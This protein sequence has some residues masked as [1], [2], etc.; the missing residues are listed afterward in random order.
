MHFLV[1]P[2]MSKSFR[3]IVFYS[4]GI[5]DDLN[6][7]SNAT[8]DKFEVLGS[9]RFYLSED[10]CIL[11]KVTSDKYSRVKNPVKW[12]LHDYLE[13]R[14]LLQA[15]AAKEY[16]SL[17][18]LRRTGLRTP[19]CYGWGV[20]LQ[21][22]NSGGSLL[23]MEHVQDARPGGDVFDTMTEAERLAFLIRFSQ[24]VALLA[25]AGYVHRDL[26]YNNLLLDEN[27]SIIW[28]DA[29]VRRLPRRKSR[30]WPAIH[31]SLTVSKLRGEDYRAFVEQQLQKRLAV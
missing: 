21:S 24:E 15:D 13:K 3:Y 4:N 28:I 26:H 2:F 12:L 31:R 29:H 25:Q 23:L 19:H 10:G 7:V 18:T 14:L 11:G 17:I 20:S 5:S 9:S 27:G 16:R 6:F 8:T 22:S 1:L 30:H